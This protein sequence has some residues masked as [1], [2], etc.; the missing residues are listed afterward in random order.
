MPHQDT[1]ATWVQIEYDNLLA[2]GMLPGEATYNLAEA[3]IAA[4]LDLFGQRDYE[5][6]DSRTTAEWGE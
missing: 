4:R 2:Q 1:Q 3:N 6:V 5:F